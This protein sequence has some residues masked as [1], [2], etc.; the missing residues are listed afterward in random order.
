MA[1]KVDIHKLLYGGTKTLAE[2]YYDRLTIPP[3]QYLMT[4]EDINNLNKII[5]SVRL[6]GNAKLK[7]QK[8]DEIMKSRGFTKFAGGTNRLVYTHP[9]VPTAVYKVAFDAVGLNDNPAEFYNQDMIK[10]YC[11]KVFEC[12]PC[13]TIASFEKLDRITTFQEFCSVAEDI[14]YIIYR[15]LLGKYVLEDIGIKFFMNWAIRRGGSPCIIDF[16]YVYELDGDKLYCDK[17]LDDG[18]KCG[19]EI[20]YDDGFNFL[21]CT[22]CG[23]LYRA[24]QLAKLTNKENGILRKG[25]NKMKVTLTI[26]EGENT[27]SVKEVNFMPEEKF[28]KKRRHDSDVDN[29]AKK[30]YPE[31]IKKVKTIVIGQKKTQQQKKDGPIIK[32]ADPVHKS[33]VEVNRSVSAAG[34]SRLNFVNPNGPIITSTTHKIGNV[35][36]NTEVVTNLGSVI[37]DAN[38]KKMQIVEKV[39]KTTSRPTANRKV[40]ENV[41]VDTTNIPTIPKKTTHVEAAS[42]EPV[43]KKEDI[44]EKVPAGSEYTVTVEEDDVDTVYSDDETA[45]DVEESTSEESPVEDTV[46]EEGSTEEEPEASDSN[47]VDEEPEETEPTEVVEDEPSSE[48]EETDTPKP[49]EELVA[50]TEDTNDEVE[51]EIQEDEQTNSEFPSEDVIIATIEAINSK[52]DMDPVIVNSKD[53]IIHHNTLYYLHNTEDHTYTLCAITANN[54]IHT[55]TIIP[56]DIIDV[57]VNSEEEEEDDGLVENTTSEL[58]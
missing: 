52:F 7:E 56:D 36:D 57:V 4:V 8:I 18:T 40:P 23:T 38:K 30:S 53:E 26:K 6:S 39:I 16:P 50:V 58:E 1:R 29:S 55:F 9:A 12:S 19:G 17:K 15:I 42:S 25:K 22:K 37:A 54:D 31:P 51:E 35:R 10:P 28:A 5:K 20:D 33:Y 43:V 24:R 27:V 49:E 2:D 46:D 45:E 14:Y 34:D 32:F 47:T 41:V 13:G 3:I 11:C 21:H 44:E 48:E